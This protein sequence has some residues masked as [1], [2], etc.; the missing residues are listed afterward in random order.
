MATPSPYTALIRW[1]PYDGQQVHGWMFVAPGSEPEPCPED[2]WALGPGIE[3]VPMVA[4]ILARE[5]DLV[6]VM[7]EHP[8]NPRKIYVYT[9]SGGGDWRRKSDVL[10]GNLGAA[11]AVRTLLEA[12]AA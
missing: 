10:L 8:S 1:G 7:V 9:P 6:L 11:I 12:R 5:A 2:A 3:S 4:E